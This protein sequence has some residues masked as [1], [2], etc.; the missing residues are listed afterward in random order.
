MHEYSV[1]DQFLKK[2][3][4]NGRGSGKVDGLSCQSLTHS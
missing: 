1:V 3:T 2:R 4:A